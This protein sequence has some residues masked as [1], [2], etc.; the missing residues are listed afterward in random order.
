MKILYLEKLSL[1]NE[2]AIKS[3]P[4]K[5]WEDLSPLDL[6]YQKSLREFF[7]LKR[8]HTKHQSESNENINLMSKIK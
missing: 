5:N 4:N 8:K 1:K 7:K 6:A 3:F 2:G